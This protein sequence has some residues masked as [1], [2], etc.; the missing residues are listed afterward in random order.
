MFIF[1]T[2]YS[3]KYPEVA[4]LSKFPEKYQRRDVPGFN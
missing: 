4:K 3:V 2:D 1:K